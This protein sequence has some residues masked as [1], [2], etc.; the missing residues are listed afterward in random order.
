MPFALATL[1]SIAIVLVAPFMGQL[2]SYLRRSMSTR[3]YVLLFGVGVLIAIA[4]AVVYALARIR[5]G[6]RWRLALLGLALVCGGAYMWVNGTPYPEVNAVERVHFVEYGLIAFLFYRAWRPAGDLSMIV[7]PLLAAFTV[8]TC[9]EWLQ[10]FIPVR[11]GEAHDVFMNLAAIVCGLLFACALQPV[12]RFA[13]R[14]SPASLRRM[15]IGAALAWLVFATFVSYVHLGYDVVVD[16]AAVFHSHYTADTLRALQ[17]DRLARWA[18]DPPRT[19]RRLSREDQYLDEGIWHIRRRNVTEPFEA[20]NENL[21][22]ERFFAPVL[23]IPTYASPAPSRW[24]PE[25]RR[26]VESAIVG[27]ERATLMSQA[28]PYP[29]VTWR[30]DAY[31]TVV[32][33]VAA[34]LFVTPLF[35]LRRENVERRS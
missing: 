18:S 31:W 26:A 32:A 14:P 12:T 17:Q 11:V 10:W 8:G 20:F 30:R 25:Q 15:G 13:W 34:L 33:L 3:A 5:D 7:L 2:Q 27:A 24:P 9:D 6:R 21:I 16:S 35:A 1:V 22:L 29:I 19:L 4:A 23:D 28:E